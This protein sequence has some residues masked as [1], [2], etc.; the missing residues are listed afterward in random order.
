MTRVSVFALTFLWMIFGFSSSGFG[1]EAREEE[2]IKIAVISDLNSA[3][4]STSY[5]GS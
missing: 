4:G 5:I 1:Q 3:Y 2:P